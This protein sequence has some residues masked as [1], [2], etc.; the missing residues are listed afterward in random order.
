MKIQIKLFKQTSA[1]STYEESCIQNIKSP[2]HHLFSCVHYVISFSGKT[3][4]L[5]RKIK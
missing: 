1:W 4:L 3:N 2:I 5:S